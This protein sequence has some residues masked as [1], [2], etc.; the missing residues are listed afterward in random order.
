MEFPENLWLP[1]PW[2][3]QGHIGWGLEKP[4]MMESVPAHGRE[5]NSGILKVSSNPNLSIVPSMSFFLSGKGLSVFAHAHSS[6]PDWLESCSPSF[7]VL[8][9]RKVSPGGGAGCGAELSTG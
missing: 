2:N 3:V 5:W 7:P 4:G 8:G 1:H 6:D 9:N